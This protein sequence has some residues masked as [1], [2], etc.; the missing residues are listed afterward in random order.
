MEGLDRRALQ[1]L[2]KEH[3]I[4]ANKS[5]AAIKEDLLALNSGSDGAA[6]VVTEPATT[7]EPVAAVEDAVEATVT[8]DVDTTPVAC[9]DVTIA[10]V[11]AVAA[12]E[13]ELTVSLSDSMLDDIAAIGPNVASSVGSVITSIETVQEEAIIAPTVAFEAD[14][15]SIP[16]AKPGPTFNQVKSA[17][18]RAFGE[19]RTTEK[20]RVITSVHG[21]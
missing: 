14:D 6:D 1:A 7:V 18:S 16:T 15:A 9:E 19:K 17:K 5:N 8:E 10:S 3:G 21:T 4:K 12:P 13:I 11:E 2:A 20:V